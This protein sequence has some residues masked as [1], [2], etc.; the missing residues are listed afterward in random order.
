[1]RYEI[2]YKLIFENSDDSQTLKKYQLVNC[3]FGTVNPT[4]ERFSRML[5]YKANVFHI[6]KLLIQMDAYAAYLSQFGH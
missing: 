6:Y 1:M 4:C 2:N 5:H 3:V